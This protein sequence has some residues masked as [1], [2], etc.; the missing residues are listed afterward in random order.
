MRSDRALLLL[1]LPIVWFAAG[2]ASVPRDAGFADVRATVMARTGADLRWNRGQNLPEI[3][4]QVDRLLTG[5]LT[6]DKA[7]AVALLNNRDLQATLEE[8]G[9][10]Q[11]DL[12]QAG[13]LRNPILGGE[14]RFPAA[15]VRP[16]EITLAQPVLELFVLPLRKR[17][18]A[19]AFEASKLRV[20]DAVLGLESETRAAFFRVQAAEQAVAS[21]RT[22]AEAAATAA[23]LADRQNRAGNITDL[24]LAA[25][26]AL[27]EQ[28]KLDLVQG[29]IE[30]TGSR[31]ALNRDLGLARTGIDWKV[32]AQLPELPA[33]DLPLAG[34]EAAAVEKRQ[35]LAALRRDVE[36]AAR[37]LPLTRTSAIEE[38]QVGAHRDRD[39]SGATT[40]GPVAA[41]SVPIFNWGQAARRRAEARYRQ[42]EHRYQARVAQV[43]SEVREAW[44]RL[45]ASRQ[46]A[47]LYRDSLVPLRR[48]L[49]EL[50]QTAYNG[51]QVGVFQL[52]QA[53][54]DEVLAERGAVDAR[55]DY[56]MARARLERAIAARLPAGEP[57]EPA[58]SHQ[59]TAGRSPGGAS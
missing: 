56:W 19:S 13:L 8:L 7:V 18:A 22:L 17:V 52:L 38:A 37:A 15:P 46:A 51:M 11:A 9:V 53:Q 43:Q 20:T 49:V 33:T 44:G 5:E 23:A 31:E 55:R 59:P 30:L 14:L 1:S 2:C 3:A 10:A 24:D 12:L 48:S 45:T 47:E 21:L 36:A 27:A 42:A 26:R 28:S 35:D 25:E 32:A 16:F 57:K 6:V 54:R 39:A 58:S 34:L 41:L 50:T 29:Q 4:A 40:T